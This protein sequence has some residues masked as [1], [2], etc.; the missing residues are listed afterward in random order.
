M[1]SPPAAST[2]AQS[3]SRS[4]L[5]RVTTAMRFLQRF[6]VF[7]RHLHHDGG[8]V[9]QKQGRHFPSAPARFAAHRLDQALGNRQPQARAAEL[10]GMAESAWTNSWKISWR[11]C[12][13]RPRRYR[14]L[15]RAACAGPGPRHADFDT[16][17]AAFGEFDG[18]ADQVGQH[19]AEADFVNADDGGTSRATTVTISMLL[20]WA[21]GPRSSATPLS[22]TAD[23]L[24]PRP[25]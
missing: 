20:A 23:P 13:A 3:P 15:P 2:W 25:A 14:A 10:A 4:G 18:V 7:G 24:R 11:F 12:A 21:R 16:D 1:D 6:L 17:A 9:N 5:L 19:L 8:R 22:R